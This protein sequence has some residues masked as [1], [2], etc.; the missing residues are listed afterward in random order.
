MRKDL[1]R[2]YMKRMSGRGGEEERTSSGLRVVT[3]VLAL[4]LALAGACS[5]S[6]AVPRDGGVAGDGAAEGATNAPDDARDVSPGVESSAQDTGVAEARDAVADVHDGVADAHDAGASDASNDTGGDAAR[7]V[8]PFGGAT[9]C[10]D[11]GFVSARP[12]CELVMPV[13]GGVSTV[14]GDYCRNSASTSYIWYATNGINPDVQIQFAQPIVRGVA[15]ANVEVGVSLLYQPLGG[16][17]VTWTTPA[18]ACVVSITSNVCWMYLDAT[19]YLISGTGSCS[20]PAIAQPAKAGAPV[21][22]GDFSFAYS[23]FP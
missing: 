23:I 18:G 5:T 21:T 10:P 2:G 22:I 7:W 16:G 11:G 15:A 3:V 4:G 1:V 14:A 6:P 19:Y 9:G 8:D 13:S 12:D 17:A 20:A